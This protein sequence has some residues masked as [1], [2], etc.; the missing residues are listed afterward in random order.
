MPPWHRLCRR[1]IILVILAQGLVAFL[2]PCGTSNYFFLSLLER[3]MIL[4]AHCDPLRRTFPHFSL[5]F[6]LVVSTYFYLQFKNESLWTERGWR[7]NEQAPW[8]KTRRKTWKHNLPGTQHV[9]SRR[10]N[11]ASRNGDC[12]RRQLP[13]TARVPVPAGNQKCNFFFFFKCFHFTL[14][15]FSPSGTPQSPPQSRD[16]TT[17]A[18]WGAR[19]A[20]LVRGPVCPIAGQTPGTLPQGRGASG[21]RLGWDVGLWAPATWTV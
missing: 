1:V 12:L 10:I 14:F 2:E 16:L 20:L 4:V 19:G 18:G 5:F 6:L 3:D 11:A 8:L 15:T 13:T 21:C 17:G 9:S 7:W